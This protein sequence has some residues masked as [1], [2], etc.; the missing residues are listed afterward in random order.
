V[1]R[2][3]ESPWLDREAVITDERSLAH[4]QLPD[5][6]AS[7]LMPVAHRFYERMRELLDDDFTVTFPEW[8][9]GPWGVATHL[10]LL[11]N[12]ALDLI[13]RP[14]FAHQIM[15]LVT[16]ARKQWWLDRARF[17]GIAL[18]PANLY[19][20]EV[21]CPT[22]SPRMYEEFVLPYEQDLSAFHGGIAY[23]HSCGDTT[24]L[25]ALID[26]IPNLKMF[27]VGPW[28][29]LQR[30]MEVFEGRHPLEICLNPV[31]DVQNASQQQMVDKLAYIKKQCR[32]GAYTVRAD[33]IQDLNGVAA[34][35]LQLKLWITAARGQLL[36]E[37]GA[38]K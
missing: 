22:L 27:H 8:G 10:R 19:N 2:S 3:G 28:T 12:M 6:H 21:N 15:Q 1:L 4:L 26:K 33:G 5:F 24:R 38:E 34:E 29:D 32:G 37:D 9:R 16:E 14:A 18:E 36:G 7:G 35:L 13:D 25:L 31:A 11:D 30:V 23:W 17:L 20:D